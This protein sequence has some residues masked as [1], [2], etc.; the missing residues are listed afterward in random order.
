MITASHNPPE[1][2]GYKIYDRYGCQCVK[3]DTDEIIKHISR[4]WI[5]DE[6]TD[7]DEPEEVSERIHLIGNEVDEA[8][9]KELASVELAPLL[10][11]YLL[12]RKSQAGALP[13][14]GIVFDSIVT[15]DLGKRICRKYK[16]EAESTLTGFKYIGDKIR[17]YG[18]DKTFLFGYEESCG[19]MIKDFTRDKDGV[20]AAILTAEMADC[21]K[22]KGMTLM[23]ALET[24]YEEFGHVDESLES[25][26]FAG[27]DAGLQMQR[28]VE[29]YRKGDVTEIEGR[30][31]VAKEDYL[32][33]KRFN[34]DG[35]VEY[36]DLPKSNV[37][38]FI[39]E[40]GSWIA[41]RPSGNEPKV[42]IYRCMW[43]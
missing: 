32:V 12:S 11:D 40:D 41:I 7:E 14:N 1:Y 18:D 35:S 13:E 23:D 31:V 42:K 30:K 5:M 21:Y 15:G 28:Y 2:N 8:Y 34:A 27:T 29:K 10:L 39:L 4:I 25:K 17:E 3:R 9:Y 43:E 33:S 37:L 38:K 20:Q 24:L 36:L 6:T 19:Y 16:V 26:D 22:S